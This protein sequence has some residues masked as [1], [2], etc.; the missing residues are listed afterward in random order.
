MIKNRGRTIFVQ[1]F[2]A[3]R[4]SS[5]EKFLNR[6]FRIESSALKAEA[7]ST[8]VNFFFTKSKFRA[9]FSLDSSKLS[10]SSLLAVGNVQN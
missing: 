7:F 3:I 9:N 5:P 1:I 2:C 6:Q 10:Q 4:N 8:L